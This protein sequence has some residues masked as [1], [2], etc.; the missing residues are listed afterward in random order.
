M[1]GSPIINPLPAIASD[2]VIVQMVN[3]TFEPALLTVYTGTTVT[4]VNLDDFV[5]DTV[6]LYGLWDSGY[7]GLEGSFSFIFD[8]GTDGIYDYVCTLHGGMTGSITVLVPEPTGTV[9][10]AGAL[11]LAGM[12][13]RSRVQSRATA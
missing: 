6:D 4:W 12:R 7:M 3:F 11:M 2:E 9:A 13:R 10:C 1:A 5:H 8:E